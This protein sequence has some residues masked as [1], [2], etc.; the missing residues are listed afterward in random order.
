MDDHER[1]RIEK[2]AQDGEPI[3]P[4]E[5]RQKFV[6]QCGVI[7]RD[8]IQII[9]REWNNLWAGGFLYVRNFA[10]ENLWKKIMVHFTLPAPEVDLDEEEPNEDDTERRKVALEKKVKH[11]TLKKMA[12]L[13]N[14][15]IAHQLYLE[16]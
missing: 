5:V 11:W 15:K 16:R 1:Y 12:E 6:K 2:V 3:A 13:F 7:V 9:V 4:K 10:K 8:Y 14:K